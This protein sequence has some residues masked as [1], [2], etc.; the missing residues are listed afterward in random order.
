MPKFKERIAVMR[1]YKST[2]FY[3]KK[4]IES[5]ELLEIDHIIPEHL[6]QAKLDE[7]LAVLGKP[8]FEVNSYFNWVPPTED[9]ME[10]S[11]IGCSTKRT[12]Q[13]T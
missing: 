13:A 8:D 2:C 1:A 7:V 10:I 5:L 9:V 11:L 6:Q 4:L 3:C 12:L